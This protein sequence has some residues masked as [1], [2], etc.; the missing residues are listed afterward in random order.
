MKDSQIIV[1]LS[2]QGVIR[3]QIHADNTLEKQ[4]ALLL[5]L[6]QPEMDALDLALKQVRQGRAQPSLPHSRRADARMS[7]KFTPILN[8][9]RREPNVRRNAK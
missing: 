8:A 7:S 3:V 1:E 4:A 9:E 6:V 5:A 2:D